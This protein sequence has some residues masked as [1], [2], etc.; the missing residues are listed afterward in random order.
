[1][2]SLPH[3]PELQSHN[4]YHLLR[5]Y[6]IYRTLLGCLLL[7]MF[8]MNVAPEALGATYPRLF[9]YTTA[10]YTGI[11]VLTLAI[12]WRH[13][14]ALSQR[15]LF[16][17]LFI[18]VIAISI[19]IGASGSGGTSLGYL[20]LIVSAAGGIL[21]RERISV[22]LA[23][24]ATL[25][26]LT[27]GWLRY[28]LLHQDSLYLMSS[29][30]LG[31]LAFIT[32]IV[33]QH[34]SKKIDISYAQAQEQAAQAAHLQQLAQQIVERMRTG[35]M[36]LDK[37]RNI[38]MW[39]QAAAHLLTIPADTTPPLK[40]ADLPS[41]HSHFQ[42]WLSQDENYSPL[43]EVD[44]RPA[45]TLKV[46]FAY[47]ND[48]QATDVLIFVE[49]VRS[50][51]QQAQ[52][53]KLASLGRLT[54]SIAHEVRNPLGA[55]SHASQLLAESESLSASDNRLLDIIQNHSKRV[56]QIIENILQFSRR[57]ASQPERLTLDDFIQ[58]FCEEYRSSRADEETFTI[59]INIQQPNKY[60]PL[61]ARFDRSQ[62]QQV[63]TNLFDNGLRH[64]RNAEGNARL[65]IEVGID[66]SHQ[67]PYIRVIDSGPGIP[68]QQLP[69]LF[70]PFF[71]T[72]NTG[73]GLGLYI[74]KELCEAN[75]AIIFYRRTDHGESCF[76]LQLAHPDKTS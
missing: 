25:A 50:L 58:E 1:M 32:A 72:E 28:W 57:K 75:Q 13:N 30:G 42:K 31:A 33:F 34:L 61:V 65:H 35:I 43:M 21:L 64:G 10:I 4:P 45:N 3:A 5:I 49:D 56:N 16:G 6:T 20:L 29:A 51:N 9:F 15:K 67:Q 39:N 37:Q 38:A 69:H 63:L 53:L 71:T 7:I 19:M 17:S 41:L 70:E 44:A 76:T 48:N 54:A 60:T 27:E 66:V 11:N 47:L 36:L 26:M 24:V 55:I 74:C 12:S 14:F 59:D 18:D 40:L 2:M 62:L 8:A 52:Q 73:S 23:A 22:L 46:N 68:S